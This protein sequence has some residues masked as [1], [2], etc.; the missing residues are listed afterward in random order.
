[1]SFAKD[2]LA[3]AHHLAKLD[4]GRPKQANLRRAISAAY[5]AAF[6]LL[7]TDAA[8]TLVPAGPAKLADRVSRSFQHGEMKQVCNA[9]R[10]SPLPDA[11]RD[12]LGSSASNELQM[13]AFSFV[14]LQ[15]AR[16]S[17]DY[18][19]SLVLTRS[20]VQARLSDAEAI[21][22]AWNVIRGSDEANVFL[23]SLAFGARWA[24]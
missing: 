13:L 24:R 19:V 14:E 9:F 18:D 10:R 11:L 17:A 22:W 23:A 15:E 2:L 21:F 16:H 5:Y 20:T 6:H 7:T 4:K 8:H 12:L 1:M 3:Q